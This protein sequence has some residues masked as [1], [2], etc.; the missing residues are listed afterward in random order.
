MCTERERET[1]T[2]TLTLTLYLSCDKWATGIYCRCNEVDELALVLTMDFT[3]E[4]CEPM[5]VG[6]QSSKG[7]CMSV[8]NRTSSTFKI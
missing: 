3:V 7:L 4:L 5:R 1:L 6:L 8:T 2:L